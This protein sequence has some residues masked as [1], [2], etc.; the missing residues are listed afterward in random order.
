MIITKAEVVQLRIPFSDPGSGKGLFQGAW[1]A[2]D[3]VL[4]RLE[5]DDGLVG[6]GEAFSY[7]CAD[8]VAA[9]VRQSVVPLL[10]GRN[11]SDM[12]GILADM[13]QK[14]HIV[15][16]YGITMFAISAADIALHDLAAKARGISVAELLGGL[17]RTDVPA[18]ASLIRYGEPGLV[19]D[20]AGRAAAKG[21][22]M[23]KLHEIEEASIRAG[24][25][26]AGRLALTNDVNCNWSAEQT[27]ELAPMLREI[28]LLWLEEP[29]FPPEDF[30]LLA[31]LRAETG[32]A[33]ATGE[34]ACTGHQ[35]A[36]MIK[37]GAADYVQPSVT[38]IGGLAETM[39]TR[40]HAAAAGVHIAHHAPYFGP[41]YLATLQVLAT[42]PEEEWFEYLYIDREADLYPA[43]PLPLDGRVAV[44][45]GPG[46][47][48]EPDPKV[49]ER[50]AV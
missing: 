9:M 14:L 42:A 31:A 40:A 36:E 45:E 24:R 37:A 12:H 21:Y 28:D 50:F 1:T 26:G 44:P 41:G 5:T 25:N 17:R 43:M 27:R 33:I 3:F 48:A 2:L 18:Y 49:L 10:E 47:G 32:L 34:N 22:G 30:A 19:R 8:A 46:L 38:K 16:R 35:F 11:V 39:A 20:M 23:I 4:L 6:W 29:V 15:G 13:R 7:F